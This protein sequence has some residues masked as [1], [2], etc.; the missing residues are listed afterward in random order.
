ME[1]VLLKHIPQDSI[2]LIPTGIDRLSQW[3]TSLR[4]RYDEFLGETFSASDLSVTST[5][6]ERTK[7]SLLLVLAG[8]YPPKGEQVWK[9]AINWQPIPINSVPT[10]VSS[11]MKPSTCPTYKKE[12]DKV[13][14]SEE[15]KRELSRYRE[16]MNNLTTLIGREVN[17]AEIVYH[18]FNTLT[19]EAAMNLPLPEWTEAY[20]PNGL[21]INAT[22]LEY[23]TKSYNEQ[24]KKLNDGIFVRKVLNDLALEDRSSESKQKLHLYSVHENNVAAV[25]QA[26]NIWT[27][28]IPEYGSAIVFELHERSSPYFIR[29]LYY[30]GIPAEFEV[31]T[32]PGCSEYCAL[33]DFLRLAENVLPHDVV[34]S[35]FG[36]PSDSLLVPKTNQVAWMYQKIREWFSL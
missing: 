8:L 7:M 31:R 32:I 11:F 22:L 4:N 34:E 10:E 19:S 16:L 29:M 21:I 12:L 14:N 5:N 25:L 20:F 28:S 13:L 23:E 33:D 9:D 6:R 17:K 35:C 3:G 24:L 27:N 26:L 36:P 2:P 30:K 18:L 1:I 15:Y